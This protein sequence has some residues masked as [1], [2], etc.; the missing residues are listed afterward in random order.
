MM[1][2][3]LENKLIRKSVLK[4]FVVR[5]FLLKEIYYWIFLERKK[6]S[7]NTIELK[8]RVSNKERC[9]WSKLMVTNHAHIIL[10]CRRAICFFGFINSFFFCN[11]VSL[12]DLIT[13]TK[14]VSGWWL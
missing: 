4:V 2:Y 8:S 11:I 9:E 5:I 13:I 12:F 14:S 10:A 3:I 7:T 1:S 6:N